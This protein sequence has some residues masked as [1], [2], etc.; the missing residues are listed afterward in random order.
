MD[1]YE[2]QGRMMNLTIA[3]IKLTK[4]FPLSQE[5]KV[6]T[7]QIIKSASSTAANYRA[8]C[9][10]KSTKDFIAKL[11]IVEEECDETAF[12][13][14]LIRS[15]DLAGYEEVDPLLKEASEIVAMT[16]RSIKTAKVSL[17]EQKS[18]VKPVEFSEDPN[19]Q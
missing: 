19:Q 17:K 9:R 2:M 1:K 4:V 6:I 18:K 10:A 8:A 11:G 3:V 16:V 5:S 14:E 12:W 7:Y 13:L 15:I